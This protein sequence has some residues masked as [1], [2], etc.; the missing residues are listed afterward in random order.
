MKAQKYRF[1][2]YPHSARPNLFWDG[3]IPS[4]EGTS[5]TLVTAPGHVDVLR[6]YGYKHDIHV[7]G[8][9]YTPI[10]KFRPTSK[11]RTV[12]FAPIHPNKTNL[13]S[14]Q[15]KKINLATFEK[16]LKLQRKNEISLT[17]RHIRD[18]HANGLPQ[19]LAGIRYIEGDTNLAT[20]EIESHDVI[21]ASQTFAFLS[22]ALGRPTIMMGEDETPHNQKKLGDVKLVSNWSKYKSLIIYPLDILSFDDTLRLIHTA[23]ADDDMIGPWKER[24]IGKPFNPSC[25]VTA[26]QSYL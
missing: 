13:L 8:W 18:L 2:V 10:K 24:M 22:V 6:A 7:C 19:H 12:L 25:V 21:V 14:D 4:W 3:I 1:F 23:S 5:A 26:V 16:L 15:Y 11:P 9:A 20:N 17:V